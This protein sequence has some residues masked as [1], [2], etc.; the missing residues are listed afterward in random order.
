MP[1]SL[2][3]LLVHVVFSTKGRMNFILPDVK[4]DLYAYMRG[5]GRE[6]K[7]PVIEIGGV[8]DHVHLLFTLPRTLNLSEVVQNLKS[9]SSRFIKEK[10]LCC[11]A[12]SRGRGVMER[13]PRRRRLW[14]GS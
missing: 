7:A 2:S 6:L 12:T 10:S 8:E 3:N 9:G 13:F 4:D 1:Q 11:L 5:I 14:I